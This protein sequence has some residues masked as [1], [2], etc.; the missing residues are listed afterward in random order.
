M[1]KTL[2]LLALVAPALTPAQDAPPAAPASAKAAEPAPDS[3]AIA[4]AKKAVAEYLDAVK[5]A[6][7]R[8]PKGKAKKAAVNE[9]AYAPVK[10]LTA[11]K[12]LEA[13]EA[14]LKRTKELHSSM[15]PWAW[16]RED[17]FLVSYEIAGARQAPKGAVIV[18]T[19]EKDYRIEE[20]GEDGEPESDSY[21][22]A[23]VGGKWLVVDKHTNGGFSDDSVSIGYTGYWDQP[24]AEPAKPEPE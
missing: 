17:F 6:A 4:A 9:K 3:P 23:P 12:T 24:K 16:A 15:A 14:E 20:G 13:L 5:K 8:P 10:K 21:L 22:V 11:P 2:L 19:R 1:R 18:N 7:P